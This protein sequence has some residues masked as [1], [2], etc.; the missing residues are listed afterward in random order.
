MS[1]ERADSPCW[2]MC[3]KDGV[4][5]RGFCGDAVREDRGGFMVLQESQTLAGSFSAQKLQLEAASDAFFLLQG[6]FSCL[7]S[8]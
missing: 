8:A 6:V 1:G 5:G 2:E 4:A 3:D 7:G